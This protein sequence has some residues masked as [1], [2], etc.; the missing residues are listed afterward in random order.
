MQAAFRDM[1]DEALQRIVWE[2]AAGRDSSLTNGPAAQAE[3]DRRQQHRAA[4]EALKDDYLAGERLYLAGLEAGLMRARLCV[5]E[6]LHPKHPALHSAIDRL[7]TPPPS[8]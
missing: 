3:L 8:S 2:R 7:L 4:Q 1:T 5:A 6:V